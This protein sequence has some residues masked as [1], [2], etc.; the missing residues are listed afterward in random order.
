MLIAAVGS[1]LGFEFEGSIDSK[2]DGILLTTAVGSPL[3]FEL[4]DAVGITV[5]FRL[6]TVELGV[7]D[8]A[9]DGTMDGKFFAD[10]G[11]FPGVF[12]RF[13]FFFIIVLGLGL[14]FIIFG[15]IF[16]I[17]FGFGLFFIILLGFGF[18]VSFVGVDVI[19][20]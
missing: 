20:G 4:Q 1:S 8:D 14:F 12:V 16:I 18:F 13:G 6:E 19:I 9:F 15:L 2:C 3:G 11:F 5:G 7:V 10:F 17:V